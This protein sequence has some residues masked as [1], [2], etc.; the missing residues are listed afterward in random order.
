MPETNFL[1]CYALFFFLKS[2]KT[3]ESGKR[4]ENVI[5]DHNDD[6]RNDNSSCHQR[7]LVIHTLANALSLIRWIR[8]V[9]RMIFSLFIASIRFIEGKRSRRRR[10]GGGA[11][12]VVY[13]S[14][15]VTLTIV[16]HLPRAP[17]IVA[18]KDFDSLANIFSLSDRL[19]RRRR[20]RKNDRSR[21]RSEDEKRNHK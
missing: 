13:C 11:F 21:R 4:R 8:S 1:V 19:R 9:N 15:F 5:D 17:S 6:E 3:R 12:A 14:R 10:R 20:R 18:K 2:K 7:Y 16:S